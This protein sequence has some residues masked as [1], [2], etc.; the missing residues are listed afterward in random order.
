M[1]KNSSISNHFAEVETSREHKG[2][3]HSVGEALTV[4]ILGALRGLKNAC[5]IS[6]RAASEHV[7]DLLAKSFGIGKVPCRYWL[8][9]LLKIV[10][11][12]S[13]NCCLARWTQSLLLEGMTI[14][15]DALDCVKTHKQKTGSKLPLSRIMFG[16]LLDC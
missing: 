15:F 7:R 3:F 1:D 4:V 10:E 13:L 2:C 12:K 6:Q 11:P 9:C 14:S 5:Q 8:L 16:C